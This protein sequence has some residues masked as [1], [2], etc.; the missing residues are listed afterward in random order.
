MQTDERT[1]R[2]RGSWHFVRAGDR[3]GAPATA[4]TLTNLK[5]VAIRA[6]LVD[7]SIQLCWHV[8]PVS[9]DGTGATGYGESMKGHKAKH[10]HTN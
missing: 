6:L 1:G 9:A 4:R 7:I 5:R 2:R 10:P 3:S 8:G